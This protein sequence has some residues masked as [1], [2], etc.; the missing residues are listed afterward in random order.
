MSVQNLLQEMRRDYKLPNRLEETKRLVKKWE[1]YG[2][3]EGLEDTK[4]SPMKSNMA[5]LLEN[6]AIR[7][8]NESN[9][10]GDL[11]GFQTVAFPIIRRVFAGL[12]A[13]E[14]VSVQPMSLPA[15][16]LFYLDYQYGSV[17]PGNNSDDYTVGASLFGD[18]NSLADARGTGGI[19]DFGTSFSQRH[20][21]ST[22]VFSGTIA[23]ATM[24]DIQNDPDLSGSLSNISKLTLKSGYSILQG[25]GS[26]YDNASLVQWTVVSASSTSNSSTTDGT[27][28]QPGTGFHVYRRFTTYSGNDLVFI[29]SGT[30]SSVNPDQLNPYKVGYLVGTTTTTSNTGTVLI[31]SYES[32]MAL[33]PTPSIPQVKLNWGSVQVVAQDRKLKAE[34]T[35]EMAQD[36][37]AYQSI[38]V[39]VEITQV[40][41]ELIALEVD[42]E[43]LADLFFNATGA[44]YYWSRKPGNF[45]DYTT[46]RAATGASFTGNV[47]DWYQTLMEVILAAAN[48]IKKKTLRGAANFVV[49]SPEIATILEA[50]VS[51]KPTVSD[52]NETSFEVGAE[53]VG[54][55][56]N[57][58]TVY[59]S[60][61]TP[62]NKLLLG[63]KGT[64]FLDTCYVYGPYVPLITTPVVYNTVDYH[65]GLGCMTRYSKKLIRSDMLG[66][67]QVLDMNVI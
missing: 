17:K 23:A 44:N 55:L 48:K 61:Y 29:Y 66:T 28:V 18:R 9:S 65:P 8:L 35:P 59:V 13:N 57:R 38:D 30:V 58:F 14:L 26:L 6:Q 21:I 15:G 40:L 54:S 16:L 20:K 32:D 46:G 62:V 39:Q 53:K 12:I 33:T 51:F 67:V 47:Q 64:S 4:K 27:P 60:P 7:F 49:C 25:S 45:L 11:I 34:W 41:S 63:Y 2:L 43:I 22:A 3:L 52:S 50:M 5:Q 37:A 56:N 19:H 10:S 31:P 36:M 1:S 24:G 42:N